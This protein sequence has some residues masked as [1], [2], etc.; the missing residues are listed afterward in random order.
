MAGAILTAFDS[1]PQPNA[2]ADVEALKQRHAEATES[3]SELARDRCIKRTLPAD[4]FDQMSAE[5]TKELQSL[6]V[7]LQPKVLPKTGN[8]WD[9]IGFTSFE[10]SAKYW[11]VQQQH[12]AL[13]ELI[14]DI[15]GS[16]E[17]PQDVGI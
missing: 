16:A 11:S 10:E 3:L 17:A 14:Q 13:A 8:F 2:E 15:R 4:V 12:E 1:Q 9:R 6:E 5:V 7:A